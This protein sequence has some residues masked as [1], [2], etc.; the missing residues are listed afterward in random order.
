[1]RKVRRAPPRTRHYDR[2]VTRARVPRDVFRKEYV[3]NETSATWINKLVKAK[4]TYSTP[5]E[6]QRE[7]IL[8]SAEKT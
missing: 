6:N 1:M 8:R 3:G 2:A 5:L 4:K 7:D